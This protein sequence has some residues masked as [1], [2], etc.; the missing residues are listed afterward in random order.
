LRDSWKYGFE[1]AAHRVIPEQAGIQRPL[2]SVWIPACA[3]MTA[4]GPTEFL[5][6]SRKAI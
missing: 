1:M 2:P 5:P 3:G 4:K 6:K